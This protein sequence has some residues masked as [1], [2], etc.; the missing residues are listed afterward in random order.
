MTLITVVKSCMALALGVL[1][2]KK[3]ETEICIFEWKLLVGI[4]G[5]YL[6]QEKKYFLAEPQHLA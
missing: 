6:F 5:H 3:F 2:E 4:V 1:N